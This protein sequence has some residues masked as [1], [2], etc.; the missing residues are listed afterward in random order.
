M[1]P[2]LG[3]MMPP[4]GRSEVFWARAPESR[5]S[6]VGSAGAPQPAFVFVSPGAAFG[7]ALEFARVETLRRELQPRLFSSGATR[8]LVGQACKQR[9]GQGCKKSA[10]KQRNLETKKLTSGITF[11]KKLCGTA[12]GRESGRGMGNEKLTAPLGVPRRSPTLV[13]TGPCAA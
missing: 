3:R 1:M 9:R 12:M 2:R 11:E 7:P 5:A 4:L 8:A 6:C 10:E 13:L